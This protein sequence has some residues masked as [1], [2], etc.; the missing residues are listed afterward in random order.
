MRR[1]KNAGVHLEAADAPIARGMIARGDR[2]S[3]IC[4]YFGVNPAR[5]YDKLKTLPCGV[6]DTAQLP[7]PGP[8][9]VRDILRAIRQL[10]I[11][12]NLRQWNR[13]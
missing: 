13:N 12:I 11:S 9:V 7:P 2:V 1:A 3:D 6:A 10:E 8:Y 5:L 4:A